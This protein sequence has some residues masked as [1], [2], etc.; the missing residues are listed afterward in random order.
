ML[1]R[2]AILGAD[3]LPRELVDV[4]EWGGSVYVRSLMGHERDDV[5]QRVR[6]QR[7]RDGQMKQAGVKALV[8]ALC[9][10]DEAGERLFTAEDAM[11]LNEK[12]GAA[13]DR[14][15]QV[16]ARLNHLLPEDVEELAG[17]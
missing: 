13:L 7:T 8:V 16:A 14:I 10:S 11:A 6:E 3:D 2:E 1:D 9:V 4:P 5:E 15:W 17:N 12:S